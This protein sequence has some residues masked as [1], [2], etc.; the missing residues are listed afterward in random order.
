M[1]DGAAR[2]GRVIDNPINGERIIIRTTGAE[3]GGQLLAFDLLL[4]RGGRVPAAHVHP[5]QVEQFTVVAGRVRFRVGRRSVQAGPGKTVVVPAGTTHWFGNVGPDPAHIR[6]EVRPALRMQELL[7][8]CGAIGVMSPVRG[9]RLPPLPDLAL[10]LVEFQRELA[11]PSIPACLVRI[12]L[13]PFAHLARRRS[14]LM[15]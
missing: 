9:A 8:R 10:V 3:T 15:P 4:P 11:I 7:E 2:A 5:V 12:L 1:F 14:N 13:A 6:V